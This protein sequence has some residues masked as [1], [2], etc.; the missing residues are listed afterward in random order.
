MK[1]LMVLAP[2]IVIGFIYLMYKKDADVKKAIISFLLLFTV[3][4]LAIVGNV[5]RAITPLFLTHLVAI[6]FAYGATV[7]Y[8]L[9]GK[10]LGL[11][12]VSPIVTMLI[13]LILVWIGNEHLPSII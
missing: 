6:I 3:I 9:R 2:L 12:L 8:V 1:F 4:A 10:L 7:Y 13:Y 5:M 11:F